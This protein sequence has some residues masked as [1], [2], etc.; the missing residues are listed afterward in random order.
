MKSVP[1]RKS[2]D[3]L[4]REY[5]I[6]RKS[7]EMIWMHFSGAP[8]RDAAGKVTGILGMC[9]DITERKFNEARYQTLFATSQDG[10]LIV[11]DQGIYVDVNPSFC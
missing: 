7:G 8:L 11:N 4:P 10:V 9:T 3:R 6:F 2:G 5:R 1:L